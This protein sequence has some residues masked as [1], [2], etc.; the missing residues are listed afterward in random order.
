[1]QLR[2]FTKTPEESEVLQELLYLEG[3]THV[4]R[5]VLEGILAGHVDRLVCYNSAK[6]SAHELLVLKAQEEGARKLVQE[7]LTYLEQLKKGNKG[8]E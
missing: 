1:M 2:K 4:I 6:G 3:S 8:G 7:V 5:L